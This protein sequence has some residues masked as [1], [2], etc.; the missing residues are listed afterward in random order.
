MQIICTLKFE[1]N[2][3]LCLNSVYLK[4]LKASG[5]DQK[6]SPQSVK[7]RESSK[8]R[9]LGN[10]IKGEFNTNCKYFHNISD[11]ASQIRRSFGR[12]VL[13]FCFYFVLFLNKSTTHYFYVALCFRIFQKNNSNFWVKNIAVYSLKLYIVIV[14]FKMKY[15]C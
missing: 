3:K 13:F 4:S 10:K 1:K 9:I 7:D 14:Y 11:K 2:W 6:L 15:G 5:W 8:E 12:H